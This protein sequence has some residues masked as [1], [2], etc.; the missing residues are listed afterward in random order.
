MPFGPNTL[1]KFRVNQ[2]SK[3]KHFHLKHLYYIQ[4]RKLVKGEV[5]VY[6]RLLSKVEI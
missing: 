2:L 1:D 6:C 3:I 5:I 4:N